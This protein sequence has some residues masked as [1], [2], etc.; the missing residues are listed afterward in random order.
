MA[1]RETP[2]D[3]TQVADPK[4][5]DD[6][7]EREVQVMRTHPGDSHHQVT[8]ALLIASASL[9][10]VILGFC[11]GFG[12]H[13]QRCPQ[14]MARATS[15]TVAESARLQRFSAF[16][17]SPLGLP[18]LGVEFSVGQNSPEGVQI[19]SVLPGTA[20]EQVGLLT[21][22]RILQIGN[23]PITQSAELI[24]TVR[25]YQPG[26]TTSVRYC[27]GTK[28]A[29]KEVTLGRL[30]TSHQRA[31]PLHLRRHAQQLMHRRFPHR[32]P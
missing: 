23:R 26:D 25:Q 31:Q 14:Q 21:G 29:T 1:T 2:P 24:R 8:G 19:N 22:D 6:R 27:R 12:L 5:S 3:T 18:L 30:P 4:R 10:G 11:L 16:P 15:F 17:A 32:A 7:L 13:A 20:A 9:G 28:C